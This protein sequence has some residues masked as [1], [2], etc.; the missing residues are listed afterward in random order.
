LGW[1]IHK[2]Q[3][4]Q[5][6]EEKRPMKYLSL[7][8]IFCFAASFARAQTTIY[9]NPGTDQIS[10]AIQFQAFPGDIIELAGGEY[11]ET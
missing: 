6:R 10:D 9:V 2:P 8:L 5:I 3:I 7:S 11:I 4:N 1:I